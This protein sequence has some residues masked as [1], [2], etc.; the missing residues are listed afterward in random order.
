MGLRFF[1]LPPHGN[2]KLWSTQISISFR[3][4]HHSEKKSPWRQRNNGIA[5]P[6]HRRE[7]PREGSGEISDQIQVCFQTMEVDNRISIFSGET[8]DLLSWRERSKSCIGVY[9]NK[10]VG[11]T[12]SCYC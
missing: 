11:V 2:Q 8:V 9:I 10:D 4:I 6:R 1:C 5:S 3:V 12:P 7:N